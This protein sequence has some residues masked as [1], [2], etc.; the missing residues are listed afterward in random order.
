M[1]RERGGELGLRERGGEGFGVVRE[2]G[3]EGL[4]GVREGRGGE[5]LG[6]VRERGGE[7]LGGVRERERG[8]GLGVV[9]ERGGRGEVRGKQYE[10]QGCIVRRRFFLTVAHT[11]EK[12]NPCTRVKDHSICLHHA[13]THARTQADIRTHTCSWVSRCAMALSVTRV[14]DM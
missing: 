4:G 8:E 3:G 2:R 13:S 9:R 10:V 11:A 7:G 12:Q 14:T 1:V 6:G 5:G